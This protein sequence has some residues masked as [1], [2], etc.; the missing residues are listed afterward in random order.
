MDNTDIPSAIYWYTRALDCKD[1]VRSGAFVNTD[2][3]EFIPCMQLCVLHDRLGEYE[4]A[5]AF[6]E[7]AGALKPHSAEYLHNRQYFKN[8]L[9]KEV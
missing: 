8:K 6:N 3:A 7:R 2:Y 4:K 5:N 9:L 1:E